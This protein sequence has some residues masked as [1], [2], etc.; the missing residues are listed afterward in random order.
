[1]ALWVARI[2]QLSSSHYHI[3]ELKHWYPEQG[4]FISTYGAKRSITGIV[5]RSRRPQDEE[6]ER[7]IEFVAQESATDFKLLVVVEDE[8]G[9]RE[10]LRKPRCGLRST[11]GPNQVCLMLIC[12]GLYILAGL[13]TLVAYERVWGAPSDGRNRLPT[14]LLWPIAAAD[15]FVRAMGR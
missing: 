14:L 1:L 10:V 4:L 6:V 3:E 8:I 12:L 2:L 7:I 13:A 15:L 11:A 5:C 9:Q